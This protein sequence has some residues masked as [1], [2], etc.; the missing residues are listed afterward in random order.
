MDQI[1]LSQEEIDTLLERVKANALQDG[2]YEIIKSMADAIATLGQSLDNK[3]T[4]I[5]RLLAMLFGPKTEKRETVTGEKSPEEK[6]PSKPQSKP[7][8]KKKGHGKRS[9]S[10]YT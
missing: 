2:D 7:K 10:T 8:K 5:K 9:A 6:E 4:S 3:A 1:Q